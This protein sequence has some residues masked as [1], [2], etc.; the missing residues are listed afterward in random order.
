PFGIA[1]RA[2]IS[3]GQSLVDGCLRRVA[4]PA[5]YLGKAMGQRVPGAHLGVTGC[6]DAATLAFMLQVKLAFLSQARG[7]G[8]TDV[9]PVFLEAKLVESSFRVD[10]RRQERPAP[11]Q[12][13][14]AERQAMV[15]GMIVLN[16]DADLRGAIEPRE[17]LRIVHRAEL[18]MLERPASGN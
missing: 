5:E 8:K 4:E 13:E 16:I 12:I 14:D 2:N 10:V 7:M 9:V 11:H 1:Q 15:P 18:E 3:L 17:I 6:C